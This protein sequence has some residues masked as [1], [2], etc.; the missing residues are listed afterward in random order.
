MK[1]VKS[2]PMAGGLLLLLA[3]AVLAR[4]FVDVPALAAEPNGASPT[5][6]PATPLYPTTLAT[7]PDIAS[8]ERSSGGRVTVTAKLAD[9]RFAAVPVTLTADQLVVDGEDF[10]ALARSGL[11]DE[12]ELRATRT[13]T[14]RSVA[15]VTYLGRPGRLSTSG[16]M[17][18]E[19]DVVSVLIADNRAV[20]ALGLTHPQLARPLFHLMNLLATDIGVVWENHSWDGLEGFLY[21]GRLVRIRGKGTKGG[22]ES[23]FEDGIEGALEIRVW[24]EPEPAELAFLEQHYARLTPDQRAK[25]ADGLFRLLTGE[26]EPAY[27]MRYGFYEGHTEYRTDP[28]AIAL[29]FGLKTLDEVEAAFPGRL[30]DLLAARHTREAVIEE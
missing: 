1:Q 9:G 18:A 22:Q 8:P 15:E 5:A 26:M 28:L 2:L 23:I 21:N 6:E 4:A 16:F 7:A 10:P 14:G 3:C 29:V 11:H 25:L 24:R 12:G 13:I 27:I 19:E 17:A 30:P 20:A